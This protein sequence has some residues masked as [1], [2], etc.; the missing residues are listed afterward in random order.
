MSGPQSG[1]S[2]FQSMNQTGINA[3]TAAEGTALDISD[4]G[5]VSFGVEAESGAHDNHV[6]ELECSFDAAKWNGTGQ[7]ITGLGYKDNIQVTMKW[8]RLKV[9]TLEAGDSVITWRLQAK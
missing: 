4:N 9:E 2:N 1:Q 3:N 7:K 8:V 5:F 6:V